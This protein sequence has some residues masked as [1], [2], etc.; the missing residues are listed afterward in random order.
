MA[1]GD[2]QFK[3][4]ADTA[5][6]EAVSG[7]EIASSPAQMRLHAKSKGQKGRHLHG[8]LLISVIGAPPDKYSAV[9]MARSE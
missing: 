6:A 5:E 8:A 2:D 3:Y 1:G 9:I 7:Q 4:S